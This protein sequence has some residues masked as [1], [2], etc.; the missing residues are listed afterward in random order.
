MESFFH[1][2]AP[3]SACG[4]LPDQLW[5]LE[6]EMVAGMEAREYEERL[7][8]GWRRFGNILFRPRCRACRACQSLRVLAERFYPNRSQRRA[9]KANAGQVKLSIGPPAVSGPKLLLY[10]RFHAFQTSRQGWPE[11]PAKDAASYSHSFVD[12]PLATEEWCYYL[13][14]QLVGVGYVDHVPAGLSAI[15]FFYDPDL[16]DRSLGTWNIL[17]LLA[18]AAARQLPYLYLGYYVAGCPSLAYKSCFVPNQVLTP[19]GSWRDF[20][21]ERGING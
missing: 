17:C 21:M 15:Y 16:R 12:N 6:Y 14:N 7:L 1:Y 20:R 13:N 8:A 11:H 10:D 5:S 18:E 9:F 2:L 19:D 3:P 4:Y